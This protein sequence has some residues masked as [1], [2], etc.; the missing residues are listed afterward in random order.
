MAASVGNGRFS[1]AAAVA[2]NAPSASPTSRYWQA[3]RMPRRVFATWVDFFAFL[4]EYQARTS[5]VFTRRTGTSVKARNLTLAAAGKGTAALIPEHYEQYS[6]T[7][8]CTGYKVS[9]EG[10]RKRRDG[11]SFAECKAQINATL[12][13]EANGTYRVH[14]TKAFLVHNHP[15]ATDNQISAQWQPSQDQSRAEEA[16]VGSHHVETGSSSSST[17]RAA[18]VHQPTST[19]TPPLPRTS[20]PP[21]GA[22]ASKRQRVNPPPAEVT[23]EEASPPAMRLLDFLARMKAHQAEDSTVE[24]RL[25]RYVKEFDEV[26]GN[27]AK[28]FVDDQVREVVWYGRLQPPIR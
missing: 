2:M 7:L 9:A 19:P 13:Q 16:S 24:S 26:N 5:Q 3:P 18:A 20:Q 28:I 12:K 8:H 11:E 15:L 14:V 27:V 22:P 17:A 23:E 6:R 10:K 25:A 21:V 1:A 4:E